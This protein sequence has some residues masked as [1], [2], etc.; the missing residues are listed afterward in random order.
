MSFETR[1]P[2]SSV[3]PIIPSR[4]SLD[5]ASQPFSIR[6]SAYFLVSPEDFQAGQA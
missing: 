4:S 2:F 1:P 5:A 3:T 6:A